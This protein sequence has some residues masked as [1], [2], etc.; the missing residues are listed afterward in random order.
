MDSV[1]KKSTWNAFNL[2]LKPKQRK[3]TENE[4]KSW[5]FMKR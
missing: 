2:E 1:G 5:I 3:K 4:K